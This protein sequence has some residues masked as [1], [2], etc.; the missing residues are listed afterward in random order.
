MAK[1]EDVFK[2]PVRTEEKHPRMSITWIHY[3]KL[4]K[5]AYQFYGED[6]VEVKNLADLISLDGAVLQNLL[7]RKIDADEYEIIAG[8]KRTL[9]C[10]YNA[11]ERGMKQFE[12]LPCIIVPSN[13]IRS[14]WQLM[15]TN[16]YHPK[17][18]YEIMK[19]IEDMKYLLENYPEEFPE[20]EAGGRM[21]DRLAKQLH[22]SRSVVSEYQ[23]I[24]H[25]LTEEGKVAFEKKEI[26]KSAAVA[27]ASLPAEEQK[28]LLD[29]GNVTHTS[30][31]AYK[32]NL[33]AVKNVDMERTE[34]KRGETDSA[35]KKERVVPEFGT[36]EPVTGENHG[37]MDVGD[38]LSRE[39]YKK[40]GVFRENWFAEEQFYRYML[41]DGKQLIIRNY[42][43][44]Y[45][46]DGECEKYYLFEEG[47][48]LADSEVCR[49]E[50][51]RYLE[52]NLKCRN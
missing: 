5:S 18:Q 30:V 21:V 49:M 37:C 28:N 27:L 43:S 50:L 2:K 23:S 19:E 20:V 48:H 41:P 32:K 51:E 17:S 4:T 29:A 1:I 42:K 25:N 38:F 46:E 8:H 13:D 10:K 52:E 44:D 34:E 14:R 7:V 9:A 6:D 33:K 24:S 47:K 35:E 16:Q 15:S 36:Q 22:M 45:G 40:W 31:T 11:E 39:N 3:S 26:D 12:F